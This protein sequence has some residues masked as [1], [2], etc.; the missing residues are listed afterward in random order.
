MNEMADLQLYLIHNS[1]LLL[2]TLTHLCC[3]SIKSS[4]VLTLL[5]FTKSAFVYSLVKLQENVRAE[6][7]RLLVVRIHT[8]YRGQDNHGNGDGACHVARVSL[9][10]LKHGLNC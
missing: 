1:S 6:V 4:T 10:T 7:E 5:V 2:L 3:Q 8:L 9:S